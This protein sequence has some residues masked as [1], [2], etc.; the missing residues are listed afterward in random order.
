MISL[1]RVE[2]FLKT[3][4]PFKQT[5]IIMFLLLIP[6]GYGIY[7]GRYLRYNSWDVVTEPINI[8]K[9]ST[10][11]LHHPFQSLNVWLFTFI[12]AS[13][14]GIIYFTIKKLPRALSAAGQF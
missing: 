11:H 9:T 6:C 4:S 12:F 3:R 14:L 8:L 13:F 2:K 1:F 7:I 5:D 10:H